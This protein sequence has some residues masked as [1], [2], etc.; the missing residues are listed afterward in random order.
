M[1]MPVP[2]P[3]ALATSPAVPSPVIVAPS[4]PAGP[5]DA[6]GEPV[7]RAVPSELLT[8]SEFKQAT[9]KICEE[10][11]TLSF[12][13]HARPIVLEVG[14][15]V[16]GHTDFNVKLAQDR[17]LAIQNAYSAALKRPVQVE[18]KLDIQL[19]SEGGSRKSL[20]EEQEQALQAERARR[21][22]EALDHPARGL[23]REVF[24]DVSFLEPTLEPEV[25]IHV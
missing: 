4:S 9:A 15:L 17:A 20:V 2:E 12:L 11:K 21:R 1:P 6:A 7:S 3:V 13:S 18:H 22:R 25:N 10:T 23:V 19:Q 24:G 5:P 16:L 8:D 14:R